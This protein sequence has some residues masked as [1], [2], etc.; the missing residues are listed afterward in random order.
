MGSIS[1][2]I[3]L[4]LCAESCRIFLPLH[5]VS[6]LPSFRTGDSFSP[7]TVTLP[8]GPGTHHPSSAFDLCFPFW[9][10]SGVF[11]TTVTLM[12]LDKHVTSSRLV[13]EVNSL[14]K[15]PHAMYSIGSLEQK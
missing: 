7:L 4:G 6:H 3:A 10:E 8:A 1:S 12:A 14:N 2:G 15:G 9:S 13:L 5:F 11:L